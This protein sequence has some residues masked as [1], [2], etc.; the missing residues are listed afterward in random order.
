MIKKFIYRRK[1]ELMI[2]KCTKCGEEKNISDFSLQRCGVYRSRCN[3]C[4]NEDNRI[5]RLTNKE[6]DKESKQKWKEKNLEYWKLYHKENEEELKKYSIEYYKENKN[7]I[8]DRSIKTYNEN[9]DNILSHRKKHYENN[10]ELYKMRG[11][12]NYHKNKLKYSYMRAWRGILR[13][14]LKRMNNKKTDLTIKMLKYSAI[15][16]KNHMERLFQENMTWNNWGEWHIHHI[17]YV[18]HFN[19]NESPCVVNALDNLIPLWKEDH[20]KIHRNNE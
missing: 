10:K 6:K 19:K 3:S 11:L 12:K 15:D 2:K 7:V 13:C 17:K 4:K 1:I 16:L 20:K 5:Y 8:I 14:A 9:K 18:C